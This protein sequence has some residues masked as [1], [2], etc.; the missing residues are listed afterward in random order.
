MSLAVKCLV[1][2]EDTVHM[3]N[4][5]KIGSVSMLY[6]LKN[7]VQKALDDGNPSHHL[8]EELMSISGIL[9]V[10]H[11]YFDNVDALTHQ[12]ETVLEEAWKKHRRNSI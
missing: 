3:A 10:P 6:E 2:A 1:F 7:L 9:D 11:I 8:D 5:D 12:I 4:T